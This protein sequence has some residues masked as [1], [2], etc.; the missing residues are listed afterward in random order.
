MYLIDFK[1]VRII[2][3]SIIQAL[4]GLKGKCQFVPHLLVDY[5]SNLSPS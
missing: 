1:Y 2:I 4:L 3:N 5:F